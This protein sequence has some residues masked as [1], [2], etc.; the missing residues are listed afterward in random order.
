MPPPREEGNPPDD[1]RTLLIDEGVSPPPTDIDSLSPTIGHE[2]ITI[3]PQLYPIDDPNI[4]P[5]Q[6][7]PT[8]RRYSLLPLNTEND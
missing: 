7:E 5:L 2:T 8:F 3:T 6:T 1:E 4:D